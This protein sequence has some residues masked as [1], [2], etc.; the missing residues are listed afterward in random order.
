MPASEASSCAT[1]L[2]EELGE[3]VE[4]TLID[5]GDAFVFGYSKL[6]VLFGRTS[7]DAVRLPY[8]RVRQ[9]GGAAS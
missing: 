3:E 5:K 9:A 1:T 2:S 4:V 6:D 7:A 8:A